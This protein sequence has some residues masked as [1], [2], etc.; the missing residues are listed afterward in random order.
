MV[1][2]ISPEMNYHGESF[3]VKLRN[4]SEEEF[5]L[6]CFEVRQVCENSL[7]TYFIPLLADNFMKHSG[8][9]TEETTFKMSLEDVSTVKLEV[10]NL[11]NLY[12]RI[13][14]EAI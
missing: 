4:E 1:L 14:V 3:P 7:I 6:S 2:T 5:R 9:F 12:I 11:Y 8:G 13:E 10:S